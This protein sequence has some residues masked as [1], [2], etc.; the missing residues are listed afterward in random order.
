[1]TLSFLV[2]GALTPHISTSVRIDR[3]HVSGSLQSVFRCMALSMDLT[4]RPKRCSIKRNEV[5]LQINKIEVS[6]DMNAPLN[7]PMPLLE[8]DVLRTF[9]AIAET[10]SFTTAANAVYRTPSAV[11]MQIK[12]LEDVLGRSV[13]SRDARSVSLTTDGEMLLGYARRMLAINREAVSK[14]IVPDIVGV[15]RLG[16]AGRLRRALAA[17]CAEAL[18]AIASFDRRRRG[19]RPERQSQP[20]HGRAHARH[21]ADHRFVPLEH[22]R[23]RSAADRAGGVGRL[24]G[25]L[26]ASARAAA[27]FAVGRGLRLAGRRARCAGQAGPQL[28]RRLY[29]RAHRRPARR[30]SWPTWQWRR[31]RNPSWPAILSSSASRTGCR[32]WAPT[33]WPCWLRMTLLRRS[34]L[35]PTIS[36]RRSRLFRETG[37]F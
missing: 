8:L 12:K 18:C 31:C 21:H 9:V 33:A 29:E 20:A 15:V 25:R 36:V 11:S 30:R 17:L 28:P 34:R 35:R 10:G 2:C 26:R 1:M 23:R 4:M 37:R 5:I 19:D 7:H 3:F 6:H 32:R 14:F 24:Q 27:G 22:G 16:L 13:F